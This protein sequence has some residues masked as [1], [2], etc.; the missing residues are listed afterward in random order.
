ME[1]D[2]IQAIEEAIRSDKNRQ[3]AVDLIDKIDSLPQPLA[4]AWTDDLAYALEQE[5]VPY[6]RNQILKQL[7]KIA[8]DHPG[9]ASVASSALVQ[10][11]GNKIHDL[12]NSEMTQNTAIS[13]GTEAT[14][15]IV[16]GVDR[17]DQHINI[18]YDDVKEFL[19]HGDAPQRALGYRLLGRSA[20]P[21]AVRALTASLDYEV[22]SVKR[23]RLE[24]VEN[25]RAAVEQS[26]RG[27]G[28]L[29][30]S[31]AYISL[32]VLY[33][34]G[35]ADPE[36][37]LLEKAQ[38]VLFEE[39]IQGNPEPTE[40]LQ[41]TGQLAKTDAAFAQS[42]VD[43]ALELLTRDSKSQ[44][45]GWDVLNEVADWEPDPI[46]ARSGD[47]VE[48]FATSSPSETKRGLMVLSTVAE[49][50]RSYPSE[51]AEVVL[52]K[53]KSNDKDVVVE[54]VR[55]AKNI[56]FHPPPEQLTSLAKGNGKVAAA[57]AEAIDHLRDKRN[58]RAATSYVQDLESPDKDI[59]L[60][61]G[62]TGDLCLKQRTED[63]MWADIDVGT[64]R[65]RVVKETLRSADR[66]ENAPVVLPHYEPR[67]TVLVAISLV[68]NATRADRQIAIYSPGS[69]SHWGMKG[70]VREEL[71][72]FGL[73]D[74]S[75]RVVGAEPIPDVIPHAY[76]WD[77]ELKND[78]EGQAPGCFVLCKKLSDL[79]HVDDLDIVLLNLS[80]RIPEETEEKIREVE[81]IHP[82][83]TLVNTYSYYAKNE[84]D[85]RPR[86]GPPIGLE[87]T[88]TLPSINAID[89]V[90]S[91]NT[92]DWT[93]HLSPT[94][95]SDGD[96]LSDTYETSVGT[97]TV[98]DDDVRSLANGSSI[99]VRH[100]ETGDIS[101]LLDQVFDLSAS[102]RGVD[103]YGS[104]GLIFSRQL[105]FERLPVPGEDFDEWIR[106]RYYEGER[107]LPPLIEERIEDVKRKAEV[108]E[109]LQAVQPLNKAERILEQI[110]KRLRDENPLFDEIQDQ[111]S[112][113][114]GN[115]ERL[116]IFSG[117]TKHAEILRYSLEKHGV[118]TQ[119]ELE[120]GAITVVSPDNARSL[121][122]HDRLV[123][124][125][126]LHQE[127]AGFYVHPRVAE[128][129]VLTY[130]RTWASMME[131]HACD[132][133]DTLNVAAGGLD[134]AP[135]EYPR[136]G[137]DLPIEESSE[138]PEAEAES[139]IDRSVENAQ[140]STASESPRS[141]KSRK[142]PKSEV[143]ADAMGYV[144]S[145]AYREESGRYDRETRHYV[146]ETTDGRL[147]NLTN[148][149]TI[150]RRR[151]TSAKVEH[152]WVS[153]EALTAGDSIVTIPSEVKE[154]LWQ[155]E[156]KQL[157]EDDFE[158][159]EALDRLGQWYSA[160][161]DI[162]DHVREENHTA[163]DDSTWGVHAT[164]YDTINRQ[165]PDFGREK[166]TVRSWFDSV[167]EADTPIELVEDPSLTIGPRSY[168]DIESIGQ[169][170]DNNLLTTD[171]EKIEASMEGL[172]TINRR[173]GHEL[174][175]KI[176][177]QMNTHQSN[178]V[179]DAAE[180]HEVASIRERDK[181][182]S[183][184]SD[185]GTSGESETTTNKGTSNDPDEKGTDSP[186]EARLSEQ[187]RERLADIVR[188][189]PT[190]NG[191][192]ATEWN[193]EAGKEAWEYLTQHLDG[194]YQR[195]INHRIEPTEKATKMIE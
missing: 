111:I 171:A 5:E 110:N 98:G 88:S 162:Y 155:E 50:A 89:A 100:V 55:A 22:E 3:K 11:V 160:V 186:T 108:V 193:M 130:D 42:L 37:D 116:A 73:S 2:K 75:G 131:S 21:D 14:Q 179:L 64:I 25:A 79:E 117:S 194:Y 173:Q 8:R 190:S 112:I 125:G 150:L 49:R 151:Q 159:D 34:S 92:F 15:S 7:K 144:S 85:G 33:S 115:D 140:E 121:G 66:G 52:N 18:T 53:L 123:I 146:I 12:S 182:T 10:V 166:S 30:S 195:N 70:Q 40:L 96:S 107:F 78:S 13:L 71:S 129:V 28:N 51:L 72:K 183:S 39:L 102:L 44:E 163:S 134:Y 86:Y 38:S 176:R 132:F 148:H 23:A 32:S 167:L 177:D 6:N 120:D 84:R 69:Q 60:F 114:R 152:H 147:L 90:L 31:E 141:T 93:N 180:R 29:S 164:I 161:E 109:E 128:T 1:D 97:W 157:Y 59:R 76:V 45:I 48:T 41:A 174:Q 165:I 142:K 127:N 82:E 36:T 91:E 145:E 113:A 56:G 189:A 192:L 43:E 122:V 138:A 124:P 35:Y 63:G 83:A 168:K 67:D 191:E 57:A 26:L 77:G 61:A 27:N 139:N 80:S 16:S 169:A 137:G 65:S 119:D 170:F 153:P 99:R 143:L 68:L 106:E 156:L 178:P 4:E 54:A 181:A 20:D 126:A 118:V 188:L 104:G 105:F 154:E 187:E 74:T 103:D 87:S 135:Y 46:I 47:L 19:E 136:L 184:R 175:E 172:R 95:H 101:S 9:E 94:Y 17:Q 185:S 24:A 62:D 149:D 58:S 158:A 81:S 133:V